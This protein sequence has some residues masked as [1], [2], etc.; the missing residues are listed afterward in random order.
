MIP[1]AVNREALNDGTVIASSASGKNLYFGRWKSLD[2]NKLHNLTKAHNFAIMNP[3]GRSKHYR[4]DSKSDV[5]KLIAGNLLKSM[6][7]EYLILA[8]HFK[9]T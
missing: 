5:L 8:R 6:S 4:R 9:L 7:K 1:L 2:T 3:S